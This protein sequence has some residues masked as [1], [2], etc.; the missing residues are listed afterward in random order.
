MPYAIKIR[1]E[2]QLIEVHFFG[3][4]SYEDALAA[5]EDAS[6]LVRKRNVRGLLV[7]QSAIETFPGTTGNMF[8]FHTSHE[9]MFPPDLHMALVYSPQTT[10]PA[11]ARFAETIAV[12][13][14][15]P[16]GTFTSRD[17]A[18]GWLFTEL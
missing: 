2:R 3:N 15:I 14:G 10:R 9:A 7:D 11:D 12:N 8:E 4:I 16:F 18:L 5:R 6:R 13:S 17:K 1:P